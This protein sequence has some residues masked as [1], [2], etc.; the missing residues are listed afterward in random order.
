M[1]LEA[2]EQTYRLMVSDHISPWTPA[3][4]EASQ[5]DCRAIRG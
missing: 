2:N 3:T 5:E 4:P 1:E